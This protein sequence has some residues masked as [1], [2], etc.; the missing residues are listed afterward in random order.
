MVTQEIKPDDITPQ[1]VKSQICPTASDKEL[2]LFIQLCKAFQ[3]NPFKREIYLVKYGTYPATIMTGYEVYLKRAERSNKYG[4]MKAWTEGEGDN[5]KALVKVYRKDWNQPLEHEVDYPEYV[6]RKKDGTIN[7][8][9]ASKPKTMLKKVAISQAFRLAFPD[10]LAGMPY[11]Q[12]EGSEHIEDIQINEVEYISNEQV[13][14]IRDY[15]DNFKTFD[16]KVFC[17]VMESE[18]IEKIELQNF[19]KAI[20]ALEAKKKL[21]QQ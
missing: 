7:K 1:L 4:G 12:E 18:S 13:S 20:S 17:E 8:F 14:K 9:W 15:I 3:L 16:E 2:G 6:Q 19:D 5:L 21:E 11:V 10:E